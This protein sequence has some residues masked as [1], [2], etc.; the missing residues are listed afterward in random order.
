MGMVREHLLRGGLQG[1]GGGGQSRRVF[2]KDRSGAMRAG[3]GSLGLATR[4]PLLTQA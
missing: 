2:W 3:R 4:R 1:S